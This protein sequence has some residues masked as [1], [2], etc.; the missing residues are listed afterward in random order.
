M[1]LEHFGCDLHTGIRQCDEAILIHLNISVFPQTLG[2]VSHAG[3]R[4]PQVLR[5]VHI[6]HIS[7][8]GLHHQ[9]GFQIILR[10]FQDLHGHH[11]SFLPITIQG[12][13]VRPK[14]LAKATARMKL[15]W[16]FYHIFFT[17]ARCLLS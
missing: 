8:L 15:F 7:M 2:G 17:N 3:L 12:I 13:A 14:A 1:A 9:H 4:H 5:Y 6:A 10:C 16:A 11:R